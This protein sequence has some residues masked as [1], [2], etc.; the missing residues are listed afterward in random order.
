M[1]Q[2]TFPTAK[3]IRISLTSSLPGEDI[4]LLVCTSISLAS[5]GFLLLTYGRFRRLRTV[6]GV[7]TMWLGGWLLAAQL[8][9]LTVPHRVELAAAC[10]ALGALLHYA[11][12]A[13]VAWSFVCCLHMFHV[14]VK[15]HDRTD[16]R[17]RQSFY[18]WRYAAAAHTLPALVV[19]AVMASQYLG[20]RQAASPGPAHTLPAL[21][22]S[23][24]MVSQYLGSRREA[25]P[26]PCRAPVEFYKRLG[27]GGH[28][29]FLNSPLLRGLGFVLPLGATIAANLALLGRTSR[30][31]ARAQ[32]VQSTASGKDPS[33]AAISARLASLTGGCWLLALLAEVS[34]WPWLRY[35]SAVLQGLQGLHLAVSYCGNRRVAGLWCDWLVHR[36]YPASSQTQTSQIPLDSISYDR[37]NANMEP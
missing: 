9:L 2:D 14:F 13:V 20:S 34:G 33:H 35:G 12:L 31:L 25:S 4:I 21:V 7:N 23:A 22:V 29:C 24:V 28:V 10:V 26:D 27:Y 8:L 15:R 19:S 30:Q 5:L 3:H 17:H 18:A 1:Y 37:G 36:L 16:A 32:R 6:P 11:W